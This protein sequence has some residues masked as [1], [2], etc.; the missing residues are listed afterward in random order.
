MIMT[1]SEW[2]AGIE[3]FEK[4]YWYI[5]IP[6]SLVFLIQMVL[7]F[8]GGDIDDVDASGDVDTSIETD[9]GI[10]F[11][12]FTFKNLVAFFTIF[13]WVGIACTKGELATW[14]TILVSTLAGLTMMFIMAALVY[15]MGKLTEE[16]NLNLNNAVGKVATVYLTIPAKRGGMGKVQIKLQGFQTLD[17]MTDGDET[18]KTGAIVEVVELVNKEILLVK[19]S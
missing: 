10:G 12:F 11:Q 6:A 9:D 8:F 16:G 14:V 5:A 3:S 4:F 1:I 19:K 18:I 17:A 7:S 2:W 15:F 13:A